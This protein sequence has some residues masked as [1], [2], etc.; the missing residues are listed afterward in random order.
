MTL[1]CA[2]DQERVVHM[3]KTE[4]IIVFALLSLICVLILR[5][6]FRHKIEKFS[7]KLKKDLPWRVL[8]VILWLFYSVFNG[9]VFNKS[10]E[11][12]P[13]IYIIIGAIMVFLSVMNIVQEIKEDLQN[14]EKLQENKDESDSEVTE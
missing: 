9:C 2:A 5:Y 8:I 4:F 1:R 13:A 3:E 14:T 6:G 12:D 11:T 10:R 7:K